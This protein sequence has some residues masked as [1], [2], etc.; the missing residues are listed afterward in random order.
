LFE[1]QLKDYGSFINTDTEGITTK[2]EELC[3]ILLRATQPPPKHT[4]FS[5]DNLFKRT[6]DRVRGE[7][8]AKVVRDIAPLI[9]PSAEILADRGAKHLEIL[10]ETVNAY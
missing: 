10:R 2:S 5:E 8:K 9:V 3:R 7:N 6:C 4:L 1:E